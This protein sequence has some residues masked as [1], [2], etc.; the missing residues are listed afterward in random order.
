MT[1]APLKRTVS[2]AP[3]LDWTD[4]HYRYFMR[5]ISRDCVLFTE[6]I[7]APAIMNGDKARLLDFDSAEHPV[8]IQLGGS[9]PAQLAQAAKISQDWG[10]DEINLN[11]GCPSDR[12]QSGRFGACLMKEPDLVADCVK[13]MQD[14]VSIPVTIKCR[15]GIDEF[16]SFE[17]F[18]Q[19]VDTLV[20]AD[21]KHFYVH[22]RKAWLNGL[23]PKENRTIPELKY[24]FV[25]QI[26]QMY[27]QLDISINGGI[28]TIEQVQEHLQY[29]DGVMIG[30]EAYH[31]PYLLAEFD[32]LFYK[33]DAL[34]I[35]RELI[36]EKM[37]IY[38]QQHIADGGKLNNITKHML[39]LFQGQTGARRWRRYLSENAHKRPK[40]ATVLLEALEQVHQTHQFI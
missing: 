2:I 12:V 31:N 37:V 27:P 11:V 5:L 25:Y 40:D 10:Y 30:R 34:A 20:N 9:D 24:D 1:H 29:V 13:A 23:S 8:V 35:S 39:G 19:F 6:M 14:A 28:Q 15:I 16:D 38:T 26:K 21:V 7:T 22:A 33:N 18:Q 32:Q 36:V 17:F 3:M 4:R